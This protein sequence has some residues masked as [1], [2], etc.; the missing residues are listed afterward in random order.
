MYHVY[1]PVAFLLR[2]LTSSAQPLLSPV[3][4]R[5]FV[6]VTPRLFRRPPARRFPISFPGS[7][8]LLQFRFS[9]RCLPLH[10]GSSVLQCV[11]ELEGTGHRGARAKGVSCVKRRFMSVFLLFMRHAG[12]APDSF[13]ASRK[14]SSRS[15]SF[16]HAPLP[17][18]FFCIAIPCSLRVYITVL[19]VF[20][21]H[22]RDVL[23]R[24]VFCLHG[25]QLPSRPLAGM[26]APLGDGRRYA[27]RR[28]SCC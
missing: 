7:L 14:F 11:R 26:A 21:V 1:R 9:L 18:S 17:A 22:F 12:Y 3:L 2:L 28:C 15:I 5:R 19:A 13:P 6:H 8:I 20:A 16:S 23:G 10:P 27:T 4:T 24:G 25:N